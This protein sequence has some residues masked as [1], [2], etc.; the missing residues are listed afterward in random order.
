VATCNVDT[1]ARAC[2]L[3]AAGSFFIGWTESLAIAAITL[4][5]QNQSELGS[6]GGIGGSIRFLITSI[7]TTVYNVVLSNRQAEEIPSKVTSAV[8]ANGLPMSSVSSF[9]KALALGPRAFADIPGI[10]PNIISAGSRA[11]K[12]ANANSFRTV[13]LTTIAFSAVALITTLFLPNF[14][15]LMSDK[16]ATTLGKEKTKEAKSE[17]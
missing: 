4:T 7:S 3:V 15:A 11:Y 16:I 9:I 8:V 6:A 5:T 13:F 14:D 2:G 10:S 12:E 17:L 1:K